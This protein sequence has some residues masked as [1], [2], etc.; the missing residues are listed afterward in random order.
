VLAIA[1]VAFGSIQILGLIAV[2]V[3]VRVFRVPLA[4]LDRNPKLAVPVEFLAY[5]LTLAFMAAVVRSRGFPF[6]RT[7]K[8]QVT[9]GVLRYVIFGFLL[10][11][12]IGLGTVLLPV[13]KQLPI[14]QYFADTTGTWM[15]A[16][17]GV[18]VAPFF[19]EMFFRGF[20]YPAL[21]RP[22]GVVSSVLITSVAF[23]LIHSPQLAH[24][25]AP[26][27][28]LFIVAVVLTVLRVRT[29]SVVPGFVLHAAYNLTL[30]SQTFFATDHFRHLEKLSGLIH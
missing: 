3:A 26:L 7:V 8:W 2:V 17:F 12:A 29:D 27:L 11:I 30:F 25:W 16:I 10:A 28:L 4:G 13:P 18:T 14:E 5:A 22:L 19:E 24:A 23:T 20:L 9:S 21:A 1:L 15:L 6:L